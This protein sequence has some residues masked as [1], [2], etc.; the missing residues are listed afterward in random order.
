MDK[1]ERVI[2]IKG[3]DSQ[4]YEQ[5]I[6]IVNQKAPREDIP[7]DFVAEAE[8]IINSHVRNKYNKN[9]GKSIGSK[10]GIAYSAQSTPLPAPR[11]AT[12][13][14]K[15]AKAK[16]IDYIIN[17]IMGIGCVLIIAVIAWGLL[18]A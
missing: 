10:V 17:T 1:K 5:A 3:N 12:K 7:V 4:W 15:P 11:A 6:F 9:M 14:A 8:K 16:P 13:K 2:L 18:G